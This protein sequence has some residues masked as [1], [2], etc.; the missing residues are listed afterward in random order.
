MPTA[1]TFTLPDV[2]EGLTE[3]EVL[4]WHVKPGDPVRDGQIIVEVE[5]AKAAVELPCPF[6]GVVAE[7]HASEGDVVPVGAP[8]LTVHA[9]EET[10]EDTERRAV[11]VGYGSKASAVTRRRRVNAPVRA[12]NG[13]TG[14]ATANG[15]APVKV[16]STP[17]GSTRA[18]PPVRKLA[19]DL[20]V[21]L[22]QLA[23]SGPDGVITRDDVQ[24]ALEVRRAPGSEAARERRI[25]VRGVRKQTAAAMV[26]SAFTAPHASEF[27]TVDMTETMR[28]RERV[29]ARREFAAIKV[30]PLLFVARA[31]LLAVARHPMVNS[32]WDEERQEIIV[33]DYVNL[34]IAAATDRGLIVPNIKDA[35]RLNLREL[36]EALAELTATARSGKTTPDDMAG[37]TISITN[38]GVYGIDTGIPILPPGEALILAFGVVRPTPWVVDG[39]IVPRDISQLAIS[40]DHRIVD[41]EQGS[42]FLADVGAYLTDP[43]LAFLGL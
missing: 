40:F 35:G 22:A 31:M 10:A 36:A 16:A 6:D 13:E 33:K 43:A 20:G 7:L 8:L 37:G 19:K 4:A 2:G 5:T 3:G 42:Q 34:G 38:V 26:R 15:A 11:L 41:G 29:K 39:Q 32:C 23:G 21:D 18:K 30:T 25:P 17:N 24:G 14:E 1:K 27:L 12:A 9:A 28:L